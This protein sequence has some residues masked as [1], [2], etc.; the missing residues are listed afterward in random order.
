[1]RSRRTIHRRPF[2]ELNV[3]DKPD[4]NTRGAAKRVAQHD[5]IVPWSGSQ[6]TAPGSAPPDVCCTPLRRISTCAQHATSTEAAP[7]HVLIALNDEAAMAADHG[8]L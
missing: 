4:T 8:H 3:D 1:M 5:R 2:V 6:V 7:G